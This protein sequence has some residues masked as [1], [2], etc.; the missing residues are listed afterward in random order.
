MQAEPNHLV[1][2]NKVSEAH[3]GTAHS[4]DKDFIPGL[5]ALVTICVWPTTGDSAKPARER[6]VIKYCFC[7]RIAN[8]GSTKQE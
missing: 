2:P 1:L 6:A 7:Q 4:Q 5:Q 3:A 8:L